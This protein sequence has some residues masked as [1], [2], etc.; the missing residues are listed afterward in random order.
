MAYQEWT[1]C[2][3]QGQWRLTWYT[4]ESFFN[5]LQRLQKDFLVSHHCLFS[6]TSELSPFTVCGRKTSP[7]RSKA[8]VACALRSLFQKIRPRA[9]R[10]DGSIWESLLYRV[11]LC[12]D[13][14][15]FPT[16]KNQVWLSRWS[17]NYFH[18]RCIWSKKKAIF[19]IQLNRY[20]YV[21]TVWFICT[22]VMFTNFN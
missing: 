3:S 7:L 15:C 17:E 21:L 20:I 9:T 6:F 22:S 13:N 5:F 18:R 16:L 8:N 11:L 14:W 4:E 1:A 19:L 12:I 10:D 2:L